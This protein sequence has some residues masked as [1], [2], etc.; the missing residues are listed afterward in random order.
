MLLAERHS[1]AYAISAVA[2][3]FLLVLLMFR[4]AGLLQ[5]VL[6]KVGILAIGRVMDIFIVA[7]G[8]SFLARSL[9]ILVPLMR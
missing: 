6:G 5:R 4:S 7:I 1:L 2:V 8:V 3:V 9:K